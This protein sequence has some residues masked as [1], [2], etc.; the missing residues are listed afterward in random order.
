MVAGKTWRDRLEENEPGFLTSYRF[1]YYGGGLGGLLAQV[2]RE[3]GQVEI[4][5]TRKKAIKAEWAAIKRFQRENLMAPTRSLPK[6]RKARQVSQGE[7]RAHT[8]PMGED[9]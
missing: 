6:G 1:W 3:L 4:I 5:T 8:D 9:A 2:E 7:V